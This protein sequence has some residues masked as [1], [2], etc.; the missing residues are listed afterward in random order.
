MHTRC[1]RLDS[2]WKDSLTKLNFTRESRIMNTRLFSLLALASVLTLPLFAEEPK[3]Q[4][5][6]A[7]ESAGEAPKDARTV[8]PAETTFIVAGNQYVVKQSGNQIVVQQ[9]TNQVAAQQTAN[10]VIEQQ[11]T[12]APASQQ[13]ADASAGQT[14]AN[15]SSNL[16][17]P[18]QSNGQPQPIQYDETGAVSGRTTVNVNRANRVI[19]SL[20]S[21]RGF[22]FGR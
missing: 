11:S 1:V 10:Q 16:P 7:G 2:V 14:P 6:P 15:Q 22:H 4:A 17:P 21:I 9:A 19:R 5:A 18:N 8:Q 3:V 20:G 13:P 12:T